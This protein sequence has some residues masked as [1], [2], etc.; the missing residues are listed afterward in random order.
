MPRSTRRKPAGEASPKPATKA[1]RA[2]AAGHHKDVRTPR[3]LG[4]YEAYA[5]ILQLAEATQRGFA[6]LLRPSDLSLAQ[7]NVLRILRGAGGEGLAC[8][9]VGERLIR[10]D[11]D[12]TRLIDRLQRRGFTERVRDTR[13]R[14]VVRTFITPKGL[15]L[16]TSL[17]A[18]FDAL[19]ETQFGHMSDRRLAELTSLIREAGDRL[20]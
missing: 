1:R 6:E 10:H 17:D 7:Y 4:Q 3:T 13:D 16:M 9:Q 15:E 11:P 5:A 8:G 18:G 20:A 14:R 12:L 19:H 2:G